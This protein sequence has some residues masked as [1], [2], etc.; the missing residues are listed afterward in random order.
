L[1]DP[2]LERLARIPAFPLVASAVVSLGLTIA[3]LEL[4][5]GRGAVGRRLL[6]DLRDRMAH[7]DGLRGLCALC[8]AVHHMVFFAC[9]NQAQAWWLPEG[10]MFVYT[11]GKAAVAVF[12]MICG[13]LFWLRLGELSAGGLHAQGRFLIHR[14]KRLTPMY[15]VA[16]GVIAVVCAGFEQSWRLQEDAGV[17]IAKL[18]RTLLLYDVPFTKLNGSFMGAVVLSIAWSLKYEWCFYLSLPVLARLG[19]V[20]RYWW[21]FLP[22]ALGVNE[23]WLHK[24]WLNFFVMG[25]LAAK[26]SRLDGWRRWARRAWLQGLTLALAALACLWT[27]DI[28]LGVASVLI[29]LAYLPVAAGA[30]WF[31]LLSLK[32]LRAFGAISYSSYLMNL[33]VGWQVFRWLPKDAAVHGVVPLVAVEVLGLAA[34]VAVSLMGYFGVE[35][36]FI[37]RQGC[38]AMPA[39]ATA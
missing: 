20:C 33:F 21:L 2:T 12:F 11:V 15:A 24:H 17:L 16:V 3:L 19:S 10:A 9:W 14:V 26:L 35:R 28:S 29:G 27:R 4:A 31:G 36:H 22:L 1:T 8:V 18:A 38:H 34:V 25:A 13:H 32:G 37:R 23:F 7:I 5:L 39:P 30:D 6:D